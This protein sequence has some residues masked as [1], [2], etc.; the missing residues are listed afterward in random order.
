M[1]VKDNKSRDPE[2]TF[3]QCQ[4]ACLEQGFS[5]VTPI[6]TFLARKVFIVGI[7]FVQ[8]RIF[9]SIPGFYPLDFSS[10]SPFTTKNMSY[11][12][13]SPMIVKSPPVEN[14][15]QDEGWCNNHIKYFKG[16]SVFKTKR[17]YYLLN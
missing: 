10:T 9:S 8:G 6:L 5:I 13:V 12:G 3:L 7:C 15:W 1:S 4:R 16:I 14:Y 11:I 2:L 17:C